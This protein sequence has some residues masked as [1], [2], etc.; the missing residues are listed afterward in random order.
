MTSLNADIALSLD[1][2]INESLGSQ[3]RR[4][5]LTRIRTGALR[6]GVLLPST[7]ALAAQLGVSR[8]LVVD[9]YAQLAAEGFLTVRQGARP[10]VAAGLAN[11]AASAEQRSA[12]EV[13]RYDLRPAMPDVG[14][15]PRKAWLSA[16]RQVLQTLPASDLGYGDLR[17]SSVLRAALA[18]YLGRV[19]GLIA[20]PSRIFITSGFAEGRALACVVL[21]AVGARSVAV[22]DPG[23]SDW[24]AVDKAGLLRVPVPVDEDG[25]DVDQLIATG[26]DGALVTP[27]HQFPVGGVLS[28][29]RRQRLV[30]W[31]HETDRYILEDDYDAEFRYD[32]AP[33]GALQGLAADRV[34]Y[35]GTASKTLAPALRLGWLVVP[36]QLIA[37][38]NRELRR[39]SE[40]PPRIDQDA[41]AHLLQSGAYDRHLRKMRRIYRDRR[42][43]LLSCL[44]DELPD[45]EVEGA[46]A[47]LHVTVRLP[48][49][50]GRAGEADIVALLRKRGVATEALGRYS[51]TAAGPRRLFIGYGRIPDSAIASSVRLLAQTI[52][53]V[54]P[55]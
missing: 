49:T 18:D 13:I 37:P 38:M 17:G 39:W 14:H 25:I 55:Q 41:L 23:Y 12:D 16:V 42:N 47:G 53:D 10:M 46:A 29:V 1:R 36:P 48:A 32:Q 50:I 44:R 20:D 2:S 51:Q 33:V 26:A 30:K 5:L 15:F 52:R 40:G 6:P 24:V 21:H 27:S 28:A 3:L 22:E 35:A 19:R 11:V 43:S 34:V 7:R 8:P 31:L 4:G 54:S 9:A 45:V